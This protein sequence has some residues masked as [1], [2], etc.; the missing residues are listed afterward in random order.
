[1][2]GNEIGLAAF[3]ER[4]DSREA[5][6]RFQDVLRRQPTHYGA[7]FQLA[8]ALDALGQPAEA[9]VQWAKVLAAAQSI[10]DTATIRQVQQRLAPRP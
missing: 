8:K 9:A 1:M 4:G 3:Y 10:G 5:V 7:G 2:A 6:T